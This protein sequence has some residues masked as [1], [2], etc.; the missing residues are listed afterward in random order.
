MRY[1]RLLE[2][3]DYAGNKADYVVMLVFNAAILLVSLA[4]PALILLHLTS[5]SLSHLWQLLTS[6]LSLPFLA[7]SL[8]FSVVYIWGRRNPHVRLS[9]FGLIT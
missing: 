7:S 3:A 4:A 8:A 1:S 9:V 2:E 6:M 5:D